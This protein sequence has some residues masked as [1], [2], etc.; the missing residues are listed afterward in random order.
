MAL[1]ASSG[2]AAIAEGRNNHPGRAVRYSKNGCPK[3]KGYLSALPDHLPR[4]QRALSNPPIRSTPK[5]KVQRLLAFH[6]HP[7]SFRARH[8]RP[9]TGRTHHR[10]RRV[11]HSDHLC[12]HLRNQ[13]PPTR[14]HDQLPAYLGTFTLSN[15][16]KVQR[17][18]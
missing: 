14:R 12:S 16:R 7:R 10:T 9:E 8:S 6:R 11:F 17:C 4:N 2:E 13:I 15:G 18:D 3:S 1:R 5:L